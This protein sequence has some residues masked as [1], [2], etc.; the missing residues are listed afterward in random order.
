[1]KRLKEANGE[2]KHTTRST[3]VNAGS[4]TR[5]DPHGDGV[6][7][8]AKCSG[9]CLRQDEGEQVSRVL[10]DRK[11]REMRTAETILGLIKERG[12]K[13]LPLE[14]LYKLLLNRDLLLEAYGKI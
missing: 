4:P 8:V 7:I 9:Q 5:G 1:M 14:R 10:E 13:G 3:V 11:V 2:P 6:P 12:K